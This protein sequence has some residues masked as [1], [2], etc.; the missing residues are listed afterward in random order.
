MYTSNK[1]KR[2]PPVKTER[3]DYSNS[4]SFGRKASAPIFGIHPIL[5]AIRA[6]KDIEKVFMQKGTGN[7][8][9]SEL[10]KEITE[11]KIP[12]QFVPPEKLNHLV[13]SKNHQGVVALLSP[14]TYQNIED[15]IPTAFEKGETPLV[16]I[17]D[18]I[19]DVR[20]MGAIARTAEC[21]GVHAMIVPAKGSAQINS[22]AIKTSAGAIFNLPVCRSENLK[23]TIDF[24]KR[25]GLQ[26]LACTE[27]AK[28]YINEINFSI[29]T[30]ILI[31]SEEDGIST[32]YMRL[33]DMEASIPL[34]GETASLNV[35]VA[36]GMVLYE[37]MRQKKFRK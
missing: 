12:F 35:S 20:N 23:N 21:S 24:L 19:T 31:G 33:C 18:R 11:Y 25:S 15:I 14:I 5:E 36:A 16:I 17:L 6:G 27:K 8:L 7:T 4:S 29:P 9:M 10:Y 13:K 34:L 32:E 22:D 28:K 2:F 37:V 3:K 1:Q 26:I 30:A